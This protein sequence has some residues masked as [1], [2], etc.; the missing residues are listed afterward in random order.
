MMQP[1]IILLREGTD[2]SQVRHD[3]GGGGGRRRVMKGG[4]LGRGRRKKIEIAGVGRR[5]VRD[6]RGEGCPERFHSER[7]APCCCRRC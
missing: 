4:I 2:T 3:L 1:G 7:L 6:S 5:S